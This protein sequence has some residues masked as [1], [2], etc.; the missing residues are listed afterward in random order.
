M[1]EVKAGHVEGKV[2][3]GMPGSLQMIA[4]LQGITEEEIEGWSKDAGVKGHNVITHLVERAIA[5]TRGRFRLP[6]GSEVLTQFYVKCV[7]Q[8][9][10]L[11]KP[12]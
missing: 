2:V 8:S 1:V 4:T 10:D 12:H 6:P 5:S 7:H 3:L 11:F 9:I